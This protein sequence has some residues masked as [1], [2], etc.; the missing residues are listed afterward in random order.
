MPMY[1]L[2][3]PAVLLDLDIAEKNLQTYQQLCTQ[4]GKELWPMVKTHN[5]TAILQKPL[6][7]AKWLPKLVQKKLCMLILLR[8]LKI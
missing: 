4:N 8:I 2:E 5:S 3:T 1:Y 6:M 7:N